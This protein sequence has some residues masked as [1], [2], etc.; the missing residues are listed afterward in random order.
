MVKKILFITLSNIGDCIL[1]LPALDFLCQ[2][3]PQARITLITAERPRQLF[4]DNPRIE[5]LIAYQKRAGFKE[6]FRIFLRLKK[7]KFDAVI[8]LRNTLFGA[9]LPA[10]YKIPA[11]LRIPADMHM[12]DRHLYKAYS[13]WSIVHSKKLASK[14]ISLPI[15]K[16]DEE[17]IEKI[18]IEN[19]IKK[20]DKIIVIA[21]GARS[22]IK[23]W[24][25]D[26]FSLLCREL[27]QQEFRIILAG[28]RDDRQI[29]DY[30]IQKDPKAGLVNLCGQTTLSQLGALLKETALLI[31]NDS[32]VLHLGSYLNIPVLA[33][34]GPTDDRKYGPWSDTS[35]VVK[36]EVFCRPCEKA[37]CRFGTLDCMR[38]VTV[39][40][41]LRQVK[42]LLVHSRQCPIVHRQNNIFKRILVVR[43]DRIGDVL[44][45][46][47]VI[48]ALREAYPDAYIAMMV[49]AYARDIAEGNPWLDEVI[50]YDKDARH[51]GWF[52]SLKFACSLK[53]R[54]FDLALILHPTNRVHLVTFFAAIP[55][56]IGYDR[57]LGMLLTDRIKH[58]KQFGEKHELE[59]NFD[60][61]KALGIRP[62][63][64]DL[65]MPIKPESEEWAKEILRESGIKEEDQILIIHPGASCPSKIW[66][67][68]RFAEVADRLVQEYKFKVLII[69]G[70]KDIARAQVVIKKMKTP[71]LNLA[72]RSSVSQLASILKKCRLFI[73]NDSGPVHIASAVGT[74]VISIFGRSQA[75]LSP[76]RWGPLGA[77]DKALHK[78]V[79]CIECLAHNCVR[80][81]TC[82]KAITVD[83]VLQAAELILKS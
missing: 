70:P 53:K 38:L 24:G 48:K 54:K 4:E 69:A 39:E 23:R 60:L 83:D 5:K 44:L 79:G 75:G 14:T 27:A 8:D 13:R 32:A 63:A 19:N 47:P 10:Q 55:R 80:E 56:R 45:S 68:E 25:R 73:S 50:I 51:K 72:G 57:K 58:R 76:R 81:F 52:G 46:T 78:D 33:V 65:F 22:H 66:P 3:F 6:N 31:S 82:L 42:Q 7:E 37:Q 34:F 15:K 74:P 28:D 17:Y 9:L 41:V 30:I 61:L 11:F 16:D 40:E 43:T 26:K 77:K 1:T 36:K 49:S 64:K 20:D 21:P 29:A 35:A 2:K 12:K 18:F 59:Y 71:A 67:N 62:A